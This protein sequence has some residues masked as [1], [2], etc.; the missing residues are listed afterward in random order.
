MGEIVSSA[1]SEPALCV[2]LDGTLVRTDTLH[3]SLCALFRQ[4]PPALLRAP[5]WLRGGKAH[6]KRELG[7]RVKLEASLLPY[8]QEL[9]EFLRSEH[10]RGRR[11]VLVTACDEG[12]ARLVAE[13]LGIFSRVIASDGRCNM[14]GAVKRDTLEREFGAGGFDYVG[15]DWC[16]LPALKA[17]RIAHLA[18]GR[19]R[20]EEVVR[21]EA[22]LG[23]IF[24]APDF[25]LSAVMRMLRVHQWV[26]N[27][28]LFVP[29]VMAHRVLNP[30]DLFA[31]MWAFAVFCICSSGVYIINDLLDLEA[32]RRHPAKRRRPFA[33]GELPLALGLTCGPLLLILAGAASAWL[34]PRFTQAILLYIVTTFAYSCLLKRIILIDIVV[35]AGLYSLRVL[36]GAFATAIPP[37]PW[38]VAFSLFMFFSLACA[39]RYSELF[40]LRSSGFGAPAG[41]GY[42]A[43]DIEAVAQFGSASGFISVLV[44]ALY[45]NGSEV[46]RLYEHQNL[47]WLLCPLLLYWVAR[48]WLLTHR[49]ELHEDPLVFA[50]RDKVSYVV[51]ALSALILLAAEG[52]G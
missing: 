2:D 23:R 45:M 25:S 41:R 12:A 37:S 13:H 40:R 11:L 43:A 44:L 21:R 48:V 3:E 22:R 36:A 20:L 52:L 50:I 7:A 9:L 5:L 16:D 32:D 35:L 39:K 17:A 29:L 10:Q 1:E 4:H 26:K 38:L 18:G 47:L 8:N 14:R 31:A 30:P 33:S 51:G 6:F 15:N 34:P 28:L 24:P 19:R 27:L 42:L 49:G 46:Q